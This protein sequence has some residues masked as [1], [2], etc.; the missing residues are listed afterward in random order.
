MQ[1]FSYTQGIQQKF[2]VIPTRVEQRLNLKYW[3]VY[4]TGWPYASGG[5]VKRAIAGLA[6]R[7][8]GRQLFETTFGNRFHGVFTDQ[9]S[10]DGM[11][12]P[13]SIT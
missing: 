3:R 9:K 6:M 13:G 11:V 12:Q 5:A 2:L 7:L 4:E 10:S 8:G 1:S